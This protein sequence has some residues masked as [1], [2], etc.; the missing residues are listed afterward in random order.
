[1]ILQVFV[2]NLASNRGRGGFPRWDPGPRVCPSNSSKQR[3][4]LPLYVLWFVGE[5]NECATTWCGV[6]ML[7]YQKAIPKSQTCVACARP[8]NPHALNFAADAIRGIALGWGCH[9]GYLCMRYRAPPLRRPPSWK[10]SPCSTFGSVNSFQSCRT[11]S[12]IAASSMRPYTTLRTHNTSVRSGLAHQPRCEGL[13]VAHI[14]PT[15]V[16]SA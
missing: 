12:P 9:C 15:Q 2:Q 6:G 5:N 4:Q 1:M 3:P 13:A 8:S 10:S 7:K 16:C 14:C 11:F